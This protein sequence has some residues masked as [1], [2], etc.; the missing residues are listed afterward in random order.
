VSVA[1]DRQLVIRFV[2]GAG[3]RPDV[4]V[5]QGR[6]PA[7]EVSELR[8]LGLTAREAEIMLLITRGETAHTA[9]RHLGVSQGTFNKHLQHIYRKL[10]VTNRNAAIAA[11]TDAVFSYQ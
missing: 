2:P 3:D 11:A 7:R 10:G 4:L 5:L 8:R 9:A 1:G 6:E